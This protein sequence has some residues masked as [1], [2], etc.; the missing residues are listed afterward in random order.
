[1]H[2]EPT[3][4]SENGDDPVVAGIRGVL[5][6]A[7]GELKSAQARDEA[8]AHFQPSRRVMLIKRAP[9]MLPVGRVWRLGV[10]L[11]DADARVY[12]TG[13]TTR[14]LE[15]GRPGFQSLSA[16]NRRMYRAAAFRG[17]FARGETVNFDAVP[18]SLHG[19]E[20]RAHDPATKSGPLVV[21]GSR[22]LVRWNPG[23]GD[24]AAV[25]LESYLND[26]VGLLVSP[27]EG[28]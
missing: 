10:L 4:D 8:L 17:P 26:R 20:L 15:P 24:D 6:R 27:P 7:V 2:D 23:V 18:I 16:E 12:A 28:S 22:A 3:I 14:A 13:T 21:R 9:V 25:D 19:D 5:N 1:M 11:L